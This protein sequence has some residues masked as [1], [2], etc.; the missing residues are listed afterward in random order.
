MK[1]LLEL[2]IIIHVLIWFYIVF[3]G[4]ISIK[5]AKFIIYVLIPMIYILHILPFH[6]LLESKFYIINNIN[7]ST[8]D[9]KEILEQEEEKYIIPKIFANFKNIFT[10][11]F[12]NPLSS[13]GLLLL[14][15]IVNLYL[16][17]YKWKE[18]SY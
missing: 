3:G 4:L 2:L 14:G 16:I 9:N 12:A 7:N 18:W 8:V 17:T 11:S 15:Y 10:S 5:H 6:L 1:L 13:Q